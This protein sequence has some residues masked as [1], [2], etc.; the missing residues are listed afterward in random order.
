MPA[1]KKVKAADYKDEEKL[2]ESQ[3]EDSLVLSATEHQV[4][5][6]Y[7]MEERER[8]TEERPAAKKKAKK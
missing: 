5:E 4:N 1:K 6:D 7:D 2:N 3:L 8:A